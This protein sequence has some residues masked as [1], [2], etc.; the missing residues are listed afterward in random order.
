MGKATCATA[1]SIPKAIKL[2]H[3]GCAGRHALPET[4]EPDIANNGADP[5]VIGQQP[6]RWRSHERGGHESA[7]PRTVV[8]ARMS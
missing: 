1:T 6:V 5:I 4:A 2:Q 7:L 3:C 8:A